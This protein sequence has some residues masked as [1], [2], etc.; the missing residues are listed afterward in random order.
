MKTKNNQYD[1]SDPYFR[2]ISVLIDGAHALGQL[3]LNLS[4]LGDVDYYV[5]NAHKWL[6]APKGSAF[7]Y[8]HKKH[9]AS[10]KPLVISHGYGS[11][12]NSQFIWSGESFLAIYC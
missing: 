2:G 8:V 1:I 5:S 10:T 9:Q 12:F 11:G 7:M 6:S 4:S 3:D